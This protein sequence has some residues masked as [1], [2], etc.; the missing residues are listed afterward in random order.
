MISHLPNPVELM[1]EIYIY[2]STHR[3]GNSFYEQHFWERTKVFVND[4]ERL[5]SFR[6]M[7]KTIVSC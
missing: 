7:K 4:D 2:I 3:D 1:T 5:W 6:D